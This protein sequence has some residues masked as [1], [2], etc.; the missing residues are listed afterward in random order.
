MLRKEA[1]HA[2]GSPLNFVGTVLAPEQIG[3]ACMSALDTGKLETY[4]PYVDSLTTRLLGAFPW[5]I[6]RVEPPFAKIGEKGRRKY[7]DRIASGAS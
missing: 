3:E 5:L 4:V 1:V 2:S 6:R 7:L